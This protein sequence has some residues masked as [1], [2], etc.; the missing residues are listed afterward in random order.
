[1]ARFKDRNKALILRRKGESYSQIKKSLGVSKSTLSYWLREFP[2]SKERIRKLRDWN[3]Q[4]IE[5][6]RATVK[7]KKESRL[8]ELF[9]KQRKN[10]FPLSER[11]LF[12][13]GLFLYW[14]EGTKAAEARLAL[15]NTDPSMI[16]F[17][18]YWL[19]VIFGVTRSELKIYLHLYKDMDVKNEIKYWSTIIN[20]PVA[21]FRKPYIKKT[22]KSSISYKRGFGH[23]TCNVLIGDARLSEKVLMGVK[24]LSENYMR[25]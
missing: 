9:E 10:I 12:I 15:T 24:A 22:S 1:V 2:L 8:A 5:K 25:V 17:F 13:S 11:E 3:E 16:L 6:Y 7:K 23:G 21:Q 4:R 20:I 19:E 14:G 18:I